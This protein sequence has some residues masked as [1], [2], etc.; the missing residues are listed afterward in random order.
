MK[1]IVRDG[2]SREPEVELFL[3][4]NSQGSVTLRCKHPNGG[5]GSAVLSING[6]GSLYRHVSVG[7][8]FG[9]KTGHDGRIEL[10]E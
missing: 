1:Y 4:E 8:D 2:Q 10:C 5:G 3:T 9:F 6:D 7:T